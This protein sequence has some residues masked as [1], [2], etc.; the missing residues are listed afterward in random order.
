MD[1]AGVRW[2]TSQQAP[3]PLC[4]SASVPIVLDIQDAETMEAVRTGLA[5][6]GG[7]GLGG[8]R[9]DRECEACRHRWFT[10]AGAA[11]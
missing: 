5:A 10:G 4:G 11:V 8:S 9:F 1:E 3:C 7:C 2:W 6:L